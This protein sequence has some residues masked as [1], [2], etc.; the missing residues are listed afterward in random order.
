MKV[1]EFTDDLLALRKLAADGA[2]TIALLSAVRDQVGLGQALDTRLDA[3]RRSVDRSAHGDDLAALLAVAARHPDPEQFPDWLAARLDAATPDW[4]GV[5][6]STIHR[7][8]GREWPHVIVH[9]ASAGLMPHRL[10]A[11]R[12]EERRVFHV[13]LTRGIDRVLVS[14]AEPP[15]PFIDQMAQPRDPWAEP[16]PD[17]RPPRPTPAKTRRAVPEVSSLTEAQ[18]RER[19]KAWRLETSKAAG[20]PA[21]VVINDAT[22]YEIARELPA[23]EADLLDIAGIGPVKVEKYADDI[24]GIV[25]AM[26]AEEEPTA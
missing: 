11:D 7:V 8:K 17:L 12:E 6:L 24:L 14:A 1:L 13:A 20:M 2:D 22:L 23:T 4:S 26:L 25:A 16:E 19:L 10:A 9:D 15:S 5:R 21:Y 18:L 3:S